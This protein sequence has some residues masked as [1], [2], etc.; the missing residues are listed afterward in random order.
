MPIRTP[1]RFYIPELDGLRFIAFLLVFI[2]NAPHSTTNE[3]WK[4]MHEYG[5]VGV[6]IFF[7]LSAFLI[8]KLLLAEFQRTKKIGFQFFY[9]RRALRICPLYFF[10]VAVIY[11]FTF[12]SNNINKDDIFHLIALVFF[13]DNFA[14]AFTSPN[15]LF[16]MVHLWTISY[17]EQFYLFIPWVV[18]YFGTRNEKINNFLLSILLLGNVIRATLIYEHAAHPMIYVL[19]FTRFE[20]II[21]GVAIGAGLIDHT[22]TRLR[23]WMFLLVGLACFGL[24][25]KLPNVEIVGWHLILTYSLT[26][27]GSAAIVLSVVRNDFSFWSKLLHNKYIVKL[28]KMSYGLYIYH[29]I[30]L[31]ISDKVYKLSSPVSDAIYPIAMNIAGLILTIIFASI[32]YKLI[33]KPFL[34]LKERFTI[35][36]SSPA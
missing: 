15:P 5:W 26:G 8:T 31:V 3:L 20:S 4:T 30:S 9:I 13:S 22:L 27:I 25:T 35:I 12:I 24:I 21:A 18:L 29:L 33:E 23:S 16:Y 36:S 28:G 2:H 11:A 7:C 17:E 19:P 10:F 6:D 32:S 34:R 1:S 14:V